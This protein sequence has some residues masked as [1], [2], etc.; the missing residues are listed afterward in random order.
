MESLFLTILNLSVTGSWVILAVLLV[1]LLLKRAP[2]KYSVLLWLAAA[3]RLV[4]PVSFE[5]V[6][7]IFRPL[8][9]TAP[10]I[11]PDIGYELQPTVNLGIPAVSQA[12]SQSLPTAT[13]AASVNP[14]QVWITLG[15]CLW[16]LGILVLLVYGIVSYC[17]LGRKMRTAILVEGRI[18]ESDEIRSPFI[19]GFV[20]PRIYLPWGLEGEGKAHVLLHEQTHLRLGDHWVKPLAWLIL[21]LH[22]FNPLVWLAFHFLGKDLEMRCDEAVLAKTG[23][24]AAYSETLLS[25]A[26][27]GRFPGPSPLAFGE[28]GVKTRI[29]NALGWKSPKLWVT[30]L[31]AVLSIVCIAACAADPPEEEAPV[32]EPEVVEMPEITEEG[33]ETEP[34]LLEFTGEMIGPGL[35]QVT[36]NHLSGKPYG[37]IGL[38]TNWFQLSRVEDQQLVPL[39]YRPPLTAM[40]FETA[41]IASEGETVVPLELDEYFP[42]LPAGQYRLTLSVMVVREPANRDGYLTEYPVVFEITEENALEEELRGDLESVISQVILEENWPPLSA[43]TTMLESHVILEEIVGDMGVTSGDPQPKDINGMNILY[44][45]VLTME[46]TSEDGQLVE[47]GGS[48]IPVV[49][50]LNHHYDGTWSVEEYWTPRDGAYY[51]P[52]IQEK[53]P[54]HIHDQVD[55]QLWIEPQM[56]NIYAQAVQMGLTDP[57]RAIPSL[58]DE[59]TELHKT[60]SV[61]QKRTLRYYGDYTLRY[62]FGE[63]LKGGQTDDRG[64]TMV[65]LMYDLDPKS[66]ITLETDT[67]QN[68]F[69][70]WLAYGKTLLDAN[71]AEFMQEEY[72]KMYMALEMAGLTEE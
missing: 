67:A 40:N 68:Y 7:S 16:L 70:E 50:S 21:V 14:L 54:K 28:S 2:K 58:I 46:V 11:S 53:F 72:P 44:M 60:N 12:V 27:H 20:R 55:T 8:Q 56:Q 48:H 34:L 57:D 9:M 31:A 10:A 69:D 64:W 29:K 66:I 39:E 62:I 36:A 15:T 65:S 42:D 4:C 24:N 22:W 47:H 37:E 61:I 17:K 49:L 13:P 19:L 32:E 45:M 63:F 51:L 25:F 30:I 6:F 38:V 52:D 23:G 18:Y 1:R 43:N 71:G 26:V 33:E 41:P 3:F 59:V 35:L 5:A